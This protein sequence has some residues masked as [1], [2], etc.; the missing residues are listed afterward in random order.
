MINWR[1]VDGG[2]DDLI[3]TFPTSNFDLVEGLC[4]SITHEEDRDNIFVRDNHDGTCSVVFVGSAS[5]VDPE[6]LSDAFEFIMMD[7]ESK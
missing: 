5:N 6:R 2:K 3:F 1:Y 4:E 7:K